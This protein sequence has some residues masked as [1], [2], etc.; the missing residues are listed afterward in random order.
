MRGNPEFIR[1]LWQE[2]S[3]HRLIM[4]PA[5]VGILFLLIYLIHDSTLDGWTAKWA[6]LIY[7]VIVYFRG[8]RVASES[9][10]QEINGK[11]WDTQRMSSV[12]PW[13]MAWAK[14]FGSTIYAWYGGL[15]CLG[16][17]WMSYIEI[18]PDNR[19]FKLV[20]IYIV[21]GVIAHATGLLVS[22]LAIQKRRDFGRLQIIFYQIVGLMAAVPGLYILLFGIADDE[23][24]KVLVWYDTVFP[25]I[26]FMV[27]TLLVYAVWALVGIWRLM[28]AELQMVNGPWV[29]LLFVV[30]SVGVSAGVRFLHPDIAPAMPA[31]SLKAATGYVILVILTYIILLSEP[32]GPVLFRRLRR[33][34][35]LADW[36]S[37]IN[38]M[39]RTIWMIVLLLVSTVVLLR[40]SET[41]IAW[42]QWEV[43]FHFAA[44]AAFL[45]VLRDVGIVYLVNIMRHSPRNDMTA[46]VYILLSYTVIPV[47]LSAM[48]IEFVTAL[49]VPHWNSSGALTI[50]PVLAEVLIVYVV[51]WRVWIKKVAID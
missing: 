9:V 18:I 2:F 31:I 24:Y 34:V 4:M 43:N 41:R 38:A 47:T 20:L 5:V 25:L 10:V 3:L 19:I 49:F 26:D 46:F 16:L 11:T 29:W 17:Y 6:I 23:T 1:N 15:I 45:F 44:V 37:L 51:L 12:G 14:L 7:V 39:P 35:K 30:F 36:G 50:I 33:Y 28:R 27:V 42:L 21:C 32:K 8:T 13:S 40:L 22:M 48:G